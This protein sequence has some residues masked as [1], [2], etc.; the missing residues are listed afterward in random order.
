MYTKR[1]ALILSRLLAGRSGGFTLIELLVVIVM[2]GILAAIALPMFLNRASAAKQTE[3]QI[4]LNTLN[5]AQQ[6]YYLQHSRFADRLDSLD[7]T[8]HR[9]NYTYEI[10]LGQA[11]RVYAAHYATPQINNVRSYV[12]MSAIVNDATGNLQIQTVL[13]ESNQ[14]GSVQ[15]STPVY[16]PS[17]VEC[18]PDTRSL[19]Q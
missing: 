17:S 4:A 10:R 8:F 11:D 7:I 5:R 19:G 13:C 2:A 15:A 16:T 6:S 1:N 14:P 18:A 3:A 12:S 9:S